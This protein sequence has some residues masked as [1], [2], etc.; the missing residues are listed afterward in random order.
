M[1]PI[2]GI[3]RLHQRAFV[4]P[5]EEHAFVRAR[6]GAPA[7]SEM[8]RPRGPRSPVEELGDGMRVPGLC[9]RIT[10]C[11]SVRTVVG[12]IDDVVEAAKEEL[13]PDEQRE[14][15]AQAADGER[16]AQRKALEIAHDHPRRLVERA[17]AAA[18]RQAR[19]KASASA[20][21]SQP[22]G[23][24]AQHAGPRGASQ[25]GRGDRQKNEMAN[26]H[27]A[28]GA[29]CGNRMKCASSR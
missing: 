13:R 29:R 14:A 8:A 17:P 22:P 18:A 27:H 1:A 28:N 20:A 10:S 23:S 25:H 7:R 19:T 9:E 24:V 11:P 5:D 26:A 3:E 15:D 12:L 2:R 6:A 4:D 21:A 16:R